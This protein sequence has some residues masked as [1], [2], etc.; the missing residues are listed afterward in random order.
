MEHFVE[1]REVKETNQCLQAVLDESVRLTCRQTE[2]SLEGEVSFSAGWFDEWAEED[3]IELLRSWIC[4]L[5]FTLNGELASQEVARKWSESI[6]KK[7]TT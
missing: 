4:I 7:E 6:Y 2:S 1:A 5:R 3:R